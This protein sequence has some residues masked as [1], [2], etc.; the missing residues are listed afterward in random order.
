MHLSA[1]SESA[2]LAHHLHQHALAQAAIGDA[3]AP[4]GKRAADGIENGAARQS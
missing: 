4:Q 2:V 1:S 3:K